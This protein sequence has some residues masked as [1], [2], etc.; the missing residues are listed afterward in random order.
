MA[1]KRIEDI[2]KTLKE[3]LVGQYAIGWCNGESYED[4]YQSTIGFATT[5]S[6]AKLLVNGMME[7]NPAHFLQGWE[8]TP[9]GNSLIYT[10]TGESY[11]VWMVTDENFGVDV[12]IHEPNRWLN[13]V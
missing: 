12:L 1:I 8:E 11:S 6:E 9:T 4:F 2:Q 7:R 3:Q 13:N 5:R 10:E